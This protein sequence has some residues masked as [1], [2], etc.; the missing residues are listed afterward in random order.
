MSASTGSRYGVARK[1]V[2]R[3]VSAFRISSTSRSATAG[4]QLVRHQVEGQRPD[5]VGLGV[6][7]QPALGV[8]VLRL[9]RAADVL[10][11]L[12]VPGGVL[13][14][15]EH[16]GDPGHQPRRCGRS[17]R[18]RRRPCP[19]RRRRGSPPLSSPGT[20]HSPQWKP[21]SQQ[22]LLV[23]RPA[24]ADRAARS[25]CRCSRAMR[26]ARSSQAD[27]RRPQLVEDLHVAVGA[28]E[29]PRHDH[30]GVAPAGRAVEE[31][32][33]ALPALARG[34]WGSCWRWC[35]RA[36]GRRRRRAATWSEKPAT[37]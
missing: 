22:V 5:V 18:S 21:V 15:A 37:S 14:P 28:V 9:P 25:G 30:G 17:T 29:L 10:A 36:T 4:A 32:D 26:S 31:G 27:H 33:R 13:G 8:E 3:W 16:L 7:R 35:R 11:Q 1:P 19:R 2:P 20:S 6:R 23:R 34:C 12:G 24:R